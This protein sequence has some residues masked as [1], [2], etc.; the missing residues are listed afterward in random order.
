VKETPLAD[1]LHP[2]PRSAGHIPAFYNHKP[3]ARRGYIF[4]EVSPLYPFGYGL[5]YSK[6]T[7]GNAKLSKEKIVSGEN[8]TLS[9]EVTNTGPYKAEEVVMLFILDEIA[10][11]TR[12]VKELKAF[13]KVSLEIGE[14]K[15]VSFNIDPDKLSFY[16]PNLNK[17]IYEAGD[18]V[19]MV[20]FNGPVISLSLTN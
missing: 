2:S 11:V 14:S 9:V 15:T 5:G 17:W 19:L 3:S 16:H 12:P 8:T 20:G 7:Y 10:S 13:K 6:I 4:D 1:W 18:F